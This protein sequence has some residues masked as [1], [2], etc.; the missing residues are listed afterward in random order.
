MRQLVLLVAIAVPDFEEVGT[1]AAA[2]GLPGSAKLADIAFTNFFTSAC[3][4][5][6]SPLSHRFAASMR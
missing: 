4:M 3:F 2:E 6:Q 5:C 1:W